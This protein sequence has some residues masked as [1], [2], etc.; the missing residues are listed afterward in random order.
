M[1]SIVNES[2]IH[3][4][5]TGCSVA[6]LMQALPARGQ[7][8]HS[9]QVVTRTARWLA[10]EGHIRSESSGPVSSGSAVAYF[11]VYSADYGEEEQAAGK[12]A[13]AAELEIIEYM[14]R[15]ASDPGQQELL[16]SLT[17][18]IS[19]DIDT[20]NNIASKLIS[21]FCV[22]YN[23][24]HGDGTATLLLNR[25]R[26]RYF[27]AMYISMRS[28]Y[29]DRLGT[30][31]GKTPKRLP[32]SQVAPSGTTYMLLYNPQVRRKRLLLFDAMLYYLVT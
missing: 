20:A 17:E 29:Q 22:E 18:D 16:R 31:I 4:A 14:R 21:R 10:S 3:S 7:G 24:I 5:P 19:G 11:A 32:F 1:Y 13:A 9:E 6:F 23:G 27:G 2:T 30:N 12:E 8:G 15:M 25:M 26:R 28:F